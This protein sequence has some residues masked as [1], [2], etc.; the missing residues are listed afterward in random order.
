[1]TL[2]HILKENLEEFDRE[3]WKHWHT[4]SSSFERLPDSAKQQIKQHITSLIIKVAEGE[5]S[6][7]KAQIENLPTQG[8]DEV[9]YKF[10]GYNQAIQDQI[11]YWVSVKEEIIRNNK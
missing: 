10:R 6:R 9:F 4:K 5:I 1:M 8:S 3:D 2:P 11:D 7:L